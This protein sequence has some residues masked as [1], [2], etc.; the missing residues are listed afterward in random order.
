MA[1]T[2]PDTTFTAQA[3][4]VNSLLGQIADLR[5]KY[6]KEEKDAR[7][8][9]LNNLMMAANAAEAVLRM[10]AWAKERGGEAA[11]ISGLQLTKPECINIVAEDLLRS[12]RLFLLLESQFQTETLFRNILLALGRPSGKTG[13]YAV[14]DETLTVSGVADKDSKLKVL[15]VP[16]LMRNSMHANGIHHGYKGGDTIEMIKGIEFRFEHEKP[17]HCGSWY[18]IVI[19]LSAALDVVDSILASPAIGAVKLI[20]DKYA[21]Q[22]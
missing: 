9:N 6:G 22:A 4:R 18:H 8:V 15:N 10:L 19:A 17:V 5:D 21:E 13:Y 12:S 11:I 1:F 14:A 7:R 2:N 20:P 3:T 16:A